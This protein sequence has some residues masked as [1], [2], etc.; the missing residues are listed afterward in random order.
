M[1]FK[2]FFGTTGVLVGTWTTL[3]LVSNTFHNKVDRNLLKP[4]RNYNAN[5]NDIYKI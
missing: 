4:I 2:V 5:L 3:S 1:I